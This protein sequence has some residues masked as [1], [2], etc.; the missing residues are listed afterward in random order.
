MVAASP[1][2]AVPLV[3]EEGESIDHGGWG[4]FV[5]FGQ[6]RF[7]WCRLRDEQEK[8]SDGRSRLG[9]R[10]YTWGIGAAERV[11][12][13]RLLLAV[14]RRDSLFG[15]RWVNSKLVRALGRIRSLVGF[16][17]ASHSADSAGGGVGMWE[18]VYLGSFSC[19]FARP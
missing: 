19:H 1:A 14:G 17:P 8:G 15:R 10:I 18:T 16:G 13:G 4:L 11:V 3:E 9:S 12:G 5:G 7:G 6:G 2:A